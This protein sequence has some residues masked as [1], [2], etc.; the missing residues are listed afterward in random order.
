M[1]SRPALVGIEVGAITLDLKPG[2]TILGLG[3]LSEA[4]VFAF[5]VD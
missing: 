2:E 5:W 4:S 1:E 3:T